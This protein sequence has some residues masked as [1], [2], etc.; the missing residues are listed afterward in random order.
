MYRQMAAAMAQQL[1]AHP[2]ELRD[3]PIPG[4][5]GKQAQLPQAFLTA[6]IP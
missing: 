1:Q 3:I 5:P 2:E 6:F 4:R